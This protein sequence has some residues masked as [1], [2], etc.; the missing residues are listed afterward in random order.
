MRRKR[1]TVMAVLDIVKYPDPC[2]R[3]PTFAVTNFDAALVKLVQDLK[4]TMYASNGAG[5][6]AIQVG[7]L[8]RIF[9]I[10]GRVATGHENP[11]ALALNN[12][13]LVETGHREFHREEGCLSFTNVF[14]Q[15]KR[16]RWAKI[17]AQDVTGAWFECEGD[18][19]LGRALQHEFDHLNGK[20]LIDLVGSL[21]KQMIKRR[22]R[23]WD[24][25]GN[26][27]II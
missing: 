26:P 8:E 6:A 9:V 23:K 21:K 3:E 27:V 7:R 19:L 18:E 12:P 17:R 22:S 4:D 24:E 25:S 1:T 2:L 11:D 15:V 5:L 16:A 13:Q 20:L 14:V 10:D